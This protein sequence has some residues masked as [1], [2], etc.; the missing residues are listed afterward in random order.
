MKRPSQ[1]PSE[2]ITSSNSPC[3]NGQFCVRRY[4]VTVEVDI[5]SVNAVFIVVFL[6]G[7][8]HAAGGRRQ[9]RVGD[10]IAFIEFDVAKATVDTVFVLMGMGHSRIYHHG[11]PS[12]SFVRQEFP[13]LTFWMYKL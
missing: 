12:H 5:A 13:F 2:G 3:G 9:I 4:I 8:L 6:D 11:P 10:G 1:T 7:G